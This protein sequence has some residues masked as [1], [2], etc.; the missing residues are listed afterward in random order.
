MFLVFIGDELRGWLFAKFK[1]KH[2]I[3]TFI[4]YWLYDS[5]IRRWRFYWR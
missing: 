3:K 2:E 1:C 4:N 5:V